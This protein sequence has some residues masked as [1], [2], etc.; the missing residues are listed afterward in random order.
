MEQSP[1]READS[2]SASNE[3]QRVL[4]NPKVL[5]RVHKIPPLVRILSQ[6]NPIHISHPISLRSILILSSRLHLG[7]TTC[8]FPSAYNTVTRVDQEG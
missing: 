3:T 8:F 4:Q 7:L 6:M 5:H 1:S 2:L